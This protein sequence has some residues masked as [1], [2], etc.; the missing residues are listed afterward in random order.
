MQQDNSKLD[1][2]GLL[3]LFVVYILWSTTYLAIRIAVREGAGFPPFTMGMMRASTAGLILLLWSWLRRENIYPKKEEW[4]VLAASGVLLWLGGNGLVTFAEQRAESGLAALMVASMPIWSALIEAVVDRR[5]P[6]RQFAIP[7]LIGFS[8]ILVL[9][10]PSLG[11][12]NRADTIA[13]IALIVATITWAIGSVLQARK[14]VNL[15]PQVSAAFQ[16][17]FG[18]LGFAIVVQLV[19][20]PLPNPTGEAWAAWVYLVVFGSI[21]AFSSY[22]TALNKLPTRIVMTYSYVNPVLAVFLGW[23]IL[24]EAVTGWTIAGSVLVLLGVTGV[25][26]ARR[27]LREESATS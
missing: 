24:D 9:S 20:E 16:M 1:R 21:I 17:L 27:K 7:L 26:R 10:V 6:S 15:K 4:A 14:K 25:F 2:S 18:A 23:L 19:G 13:L 22:V 11:S 12:G 8:G 3:H 5:W